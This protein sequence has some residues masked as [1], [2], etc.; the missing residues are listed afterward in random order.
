MPTR[1]RADPKR[2]RSARLAINALAARAAKAQAHDIPIVLV[3]RTRDK[4]HVK[5]VIEA[6]R[7][8]PTRVLRGDDGESNL[9]LRVAGEEYAL[10]RIA[11]I[12]RQRSS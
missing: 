7:V 1:K 2:D 5:G 10:E 6:R 9:L 8:D 11:E 3:L 12:R 4:R